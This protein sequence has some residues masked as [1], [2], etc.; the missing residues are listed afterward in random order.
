[1][2]FDRPDWVRRLNAMA[3]GVGGAAAMVSL[4]PDGLLAYARAATEL[5]D[6]GDAAGPEGWPNTDWEAAF[7]KLV[8]SLDTEAELNVVGRLMSR[9]DVLRHLCTR[10]LLVEAHRADP[11]I[12]DEA[13]LAPVVVTGPARSGTS[14]LHELLAED[15][16]LQAPRA[17]EMAYPLPPPGTSDAQ[18]IAWSEPEF[19]LWPD[20]QPEFA[21]VHEL[22]ARLPEECIWLLAPEFDSGFWATCT[23]VPSFLAWRAG[24]DPLPAYATHRSFLQVLQRGREP[25]PW[26]LKSPV[27][28]SRL[29]AL[30]AVYPDARVIRTHRDPVRTVTSAV[31]TVATGRWL[32]SDAVNPLD[33]A[34]SVGFGFQMIL[35]GAADQRGSLPDGQV[36]ELHYLDF[37]RDPVA[38]IAQAYSD[39]G[40]AVAP[41]LP[42][43]ITRYLAARPQSKF[44]T[45]RY[46]LADYGLDA[47]TIRREFA[48]YIEAFGVVA[49]DEPT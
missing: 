42:D 32:R 18:R 47:A 46:S 38:A 44:G 8:D 27:H 6:F 45:H 12:A 48:P 20:V 33:V 5:D 15:P 29:P 17:F 40:M 3:P 37:L 22:S 49:E 39:L 10:L 41:E 43:R 13:V 23:S 2:P 14:I 7:R 28:L 11:S 31:S 34:A 35:N 26:V 25:R 21:A 36:A 9:H 16:Q 30:F 19:D 24:T 1:M 4:D